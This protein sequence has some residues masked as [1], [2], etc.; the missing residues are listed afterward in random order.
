MFPRL[1]SE[2]NRLL[3]RYERMGNR[4]PHGRGSE[5]LFKQSN[6]FPSHDRKGVELR[7]TS[8]FF[9]GARGRFYRTLANSMFPRLASESNRLLRRYE[10]M[11][12]RLPHGRGSEEL[13]KQS[14]MLPSHDRKGVELRCT[15]GF[16]R[17]ARGRFY[18]TLAN[19]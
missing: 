10:R 1:A 4:L 8:G 19:S 17:G 3:R 13:F 12:N 16:F 11:G 5:E 7:C 14:N 6:M 15:S 18:R 9:R 2:S